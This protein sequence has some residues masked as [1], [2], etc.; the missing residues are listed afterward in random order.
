MGPWRSW[1]LLWCNCCVQ[2]NSQ[3]TG[4]RRNVELILDRSH[5]CSE[6]YWLVC[7]SIADHFQSLCTSLRQN[8]VPPISPSQL[9]VSCLTTKFNG[10]FNFPPS[11]NLPL[12]KELLGL[13]VQ[14][15]TT[16]SRAI[17]HF[18]SGHPSSWRLPSSQFTVRSRQH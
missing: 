14:Q 17:A 16:S 10:H 8:A 2:A 4:Y 12:W 11:L 18:N 15:P 9:A 5:S 6:H 13:F 7:L 1:R 3:Q